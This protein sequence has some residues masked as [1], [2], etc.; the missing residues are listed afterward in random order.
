[1]RFKAF[2]NESSTNC[3]VFEILC[4]GNRDYLILLEWNGSRTWIMVMKRL[5]LRSLWFQ[6]GNNC[7]S[8]THLYGQNNGF[9]LG[10]NRFWVR[11]SSSP[12]GK[13]H[14]L[15][16]WINLKFIN[17]FEK[18]KVYGSKY[19]KPQ[20]DINSDAQDYPYFQ[21]ILTSHHVSAIER[22]CLGCTSI[23]TD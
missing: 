10:I 21:V 16:I 18:S 14:L 4:D 22:A 7:F 17:V 1:M 19:I 2:H 15:F 12:Y 3:C 11:V 5:K 23:S 8:N 13:H 20:G 6:V 9:H